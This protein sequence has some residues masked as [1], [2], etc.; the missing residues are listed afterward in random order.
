MIRIKNKKTRASAGFTLIEVLVSI[1]ILALGILVVSQMTVLGMKATRTIAANKASRETLAKGME[2]LKMLNTGDALL[3]YT[4]SDY[5][6]IDDTLNAR[7]A[8]TTNIVG[9]TLKFLPLNFSVRWNV[10]DDYPQAGL[11][12]IRMFVMQKG[13]RLLQGDYVRW[14]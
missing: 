8:D 3:T 6:T 11:K 4:Q 13:K 14:R 5:T 10:V 7:R 9:K 2:V 1:V 12:T